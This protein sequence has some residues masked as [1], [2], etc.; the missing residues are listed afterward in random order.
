[1]IEASFLAAFLGG[2]LALLSPCSALLLPA[3]FAYAFADA[4]TIV[5]RTALFY[6]GLSATLIPLGMGIAAVSRLFYGYRS[7][8]IWGAGLI[9]IVLGVMQLLGR[10]FSVLSYGQGTAANHGGRALSTFTLGATYGL[11]GFCSGP[12]LGAI[13]TVA[14]ASG[15]PLQGA[16]L[17]AVY[18]AGMAFPL[19]LLALMWSR[20]GDR[21][22]WL[23][24]RQV[25][26]GRFDI[27]SN[28]LISGT[29][30]V[31]LGATFI[32]FQGGSGLSSLYERFGAA[33]VA[34]TVE[35]WIQS[36]GGTVDD[37]LIAPALA[38]LLGI[39]ALVRISRRGRSRPAVTE[40]DR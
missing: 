31:V 36:V 21:V 33:S 9:L 6:L 40:T 22:R 8:L 25:R 12:I 27:H 20:H 10:G 29:M 34:Y 11:A 24:G 3:F 37:W 18:A 30:F 15:D 7:T 17:L 38:V 16:A 5:R 23:R 35:T 32:I 2:L 4:R 19:L 26:I 39:V 1:M 14:A 13:L 28:R